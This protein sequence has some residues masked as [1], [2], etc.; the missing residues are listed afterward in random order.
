MNALSKRIGTYRTPIKGF[1]ILLIVFYHIKMPMPGILGTLHDLCYG[2]VD[3]FFFLTGYGFA[4]SLSK[5]DVLSFYRRR[6]KRLL[7]AYIPVA[8]LW[9]LIVPLLYGLEMSETLKSLA[10]NFTLLG[11]FGGVKHTVNW[12]ISALTAAVILA[13]VLYAVLKPADGK[14]ALRWAA[15]MLLSFLLGI[16]FVGNDLIMAVSR[17]PVYAIGMM[18]GLLSMGEED[19][20]KKPSGKQ[21]SLFLLPFA[22]GITVLLLIMR[23]LPNLLNDFG[24]YWYPFVMIAPSLCILLSY[25]FSLPKHSDQWLRPLTVLGES[26]FEIFLV[27]VL[28]EVIGNKVAGKSVLWIVFGVL[29]IILGL[30]YHRLLQSYVKAKHYENS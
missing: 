21:I 4:Y 5:G 11:W 23:R 7:P 6:A 17:L 13:P 18:A 8:V 14:R 20:T 9:M 15:V 29:S 26:S 16:A 3:V 19:N 12:Y 24:M 2:G 27:N 30:L 28:L 10:A 1:A 25:L 22:G